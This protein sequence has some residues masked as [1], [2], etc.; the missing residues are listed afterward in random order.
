M[1]A[2]V[3]AITATLVHVGAAHADPS[4]QGKRLV[5]LGDSY[6]ANV[7]N[8]WASAHTC[9][10]G[11]TAWPTQLSELMGLSGD[12]QVANTSCLGAS[13]DTGPGYTLAIEARDADQAGAFGPR[14]QL[15]TLQFGLNDRWGTASRPLWEAMQQCAFNLVAGC[16]TDRVARGDLPDPSSVTGRAYADRIRNVVSYIRYY[17]PRAH[18]VVVGY[19]EV[20]AADR[21]SVCLDFFGLV[22]FTQ[23][24]G[25]TIVEYFDRIDRAQREAA[26]QLGLDFLDTRALTTGHGLCSPQ[27]WVNGVFDPNTELDGLPVHPSPQG[28]AVVAHAIYQRYAR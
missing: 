10:H 15:V 12:E 5:V 18:I 23:P 24:R 21:H 25:R 3:V 9:V 6:T 1:V 28:D 20:V 27:P 13:I 4:Q 2:V 16:D 7:W 17:A 26:A 22:D 19:P 8:P 14:T 11:Q